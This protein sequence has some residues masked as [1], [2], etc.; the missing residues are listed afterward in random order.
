[1][2]LAVLSQIQTSSSGSIRGASREPADDDSDGD[3]VAKQDQQQ[4]RADGA[5]REDVHSEKSLRSTSA[6]AS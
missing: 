1:M 4:P 3:Q 5:F 6:H 2:F